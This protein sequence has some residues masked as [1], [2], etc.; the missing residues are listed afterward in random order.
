[1]HVY[2]EKPEVGGQWTE[3]ERE[4]EKVAATIGARRAAFVLYSSAGLLTLL[5]SLAAG[6]DGRAGPPPLPCPR[7]AAVAIV[8]AA[9]YSPGQAL[10][11]CLLRAFIGVAIYPVVR[12]SYPDDEPGVFAAWR[13][14]AGRWSIV[15]SCCQDLSGR[16][17]V[18][19]I[20]VLDEPASGG[21]WVKGT[22][23]RPSRLVLLGRPPQ[24]ANNGLAYPD[25]KRRLGHLGCLGCFRALT[26]LIAARRHR[27]A[28]CW[29]DR[30]QPKRH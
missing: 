17:G 23:A 22:R 21:P 3:G 13:T 18:R 11:S 28:V 5:V 4:A 1:V 24:F 16:I 20:A 29:T 10:P 6:P 19:R 9:A 2:K 7:S 12:R 25:S 8:P 30:R 26:T 15:A 27:L 14:P